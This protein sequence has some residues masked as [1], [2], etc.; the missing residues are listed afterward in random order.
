MQMPILPGRSLPVISI[1]YLRLK[2]SQNRE[3]G[4]QVIWGKKDIHFLDS[5]GARIYET[6]QGHIWH[7]KGMVWK[8][9]FKTQDLKHVQRLKKVKEVHKGD[10]DPWDNL[11]FTFSRF[12]FILLFTFD[13]SSDDHR[14]LGLSFL[15]C[16]MGLKTVHSEL[17]E[18]LRTNK[19]SHWKCCDK[20]RASW[21]FLDFRKNN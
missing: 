1:H 2:E 15:I 9:N 16:D 10:W 8:Y 17:T 7:M 21:I 5:S 12:T 6:P 20:S 11:G 3:K 14:T 19:V 13:H 18:F 4:F